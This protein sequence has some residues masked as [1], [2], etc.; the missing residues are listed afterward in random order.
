LE[1]EEPQELQITT[2]AQEQEALKEA[3]HATLLDSEED[4]LIQPKKK[5]KGDKLTE[6]QEYQ[7][8][9]ASTL[10]DEASQK[11]LQELK[12]LVSQP[13]GTLDAETEN[14]EAFLAKYLLNR[15]WLDPDAPTPELYEDPSSDEEKAEEFETKYNFRFE[16]PGAAEVTTHARTISSTRRGDE[17]RKRER[18]RKKAQKEEEKRKEME[19]IARL[20]NLK[21]IEL[22]ERIKKVES[23]AGRHGWTEKDLEGDFDP[24]E[25][26]RRMEGVF[27]ESYYNEVYSF[28]KV[29]TDK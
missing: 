1:D 19:E 4:D 26:D 15:G 11:M 7:K 20:R 14:G 24:E 9:L 5:S 3:F 10:Q 6:E 12:T 8:F 13:S 27:D 29:E 16:Q 17:K 28:Y 23:V 25:W 21:R 22:E 18:E 2:Y